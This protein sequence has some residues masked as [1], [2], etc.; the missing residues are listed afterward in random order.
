MPAIELSNEDLDLQ[1]E[2]VPAFRILYFNQYSL[3]S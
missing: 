3:L 1:T 2:L